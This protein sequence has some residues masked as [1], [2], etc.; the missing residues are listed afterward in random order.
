MGSGGKKTCLS[1]LKGPHPFEGIVLWIEGRGQGG[2]KKEKLQKR[3]RGLGRLREEKG[4][5]QSLGV[6][7]TLEEGKKNKISKQDC[8]RPQLARRQKKRQKNLAEGEVVLSKKGGGKRRG[9]TKKRRKG[10]RKND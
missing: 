7:N 6:S 8:P 9:A 3:R 5:A 10:V 4:P 1:T 2:K